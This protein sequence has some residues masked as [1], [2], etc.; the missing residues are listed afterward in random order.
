[1]KANHRNVLAYPPLKAG[2]GKS[3]F[4]TYFMSYFLLV[5]SKECLQTWNAIDMI[6]CGIPG[7][8][9]DLK[10]KQKILRKPDELMIKMICD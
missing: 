7:G 5:R 8:R 6:T 2:T 1:M 4:V 10:S 9:L 3:H